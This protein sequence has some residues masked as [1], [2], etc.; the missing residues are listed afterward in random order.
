M[1]PDSG[2]PIS[3]TPTDA[4]ENTAA[5]QQ[6]TL[7]PERE[8]FWG[9]LDLA[10]VLGLLIAAMVLI[11][12]GVALV[13]LAYPRF[14]TDPTPLL[15]PTNIALYL[16]LYLVFKM[17]FLVRYKKDVFSSLGWRRTRPKLLVIAGLSGL[18][19]ALLVN[20][21]AKLLHTP[22]IETPF[23][24]LAKSPTMLAMVGAMAVLIAPLFEE[25]FF[26]GFLQPLLSRTLGV[27]AGIALT[28]LLFGG[29]HAFQYSFVW[30]YVFAVSLVGVALGVLRSRTNSIIPTTVLHGCYNAIFIVALAVQK[31]SHT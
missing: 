23:D 18:P 22:Q 6:P 8:P 12:V 29:L 17:V 16:C 3:S 19:L 21:V 26:R 25:M 10:L 9:Y 30:Q 13:A 2:D 7:P 27:S 11:A 24:D 31:N 28:A 14:R 1:L 5:V 15:V 4:G 20:G